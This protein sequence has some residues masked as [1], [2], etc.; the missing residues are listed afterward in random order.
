M[1]PSTNTHEMKQILSKNQNKINK[2][3]N[4]KE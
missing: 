1:Y 4:A 3:I 2:I